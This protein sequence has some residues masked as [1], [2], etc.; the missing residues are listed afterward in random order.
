[1]SKVIKRWKGAIMRTHENIF[2]IVVI[3]MFSLLVPF[4]LFAFA[5]D[6]EDT[7][8]SLSGINGIHLYVQSLDPEIEKE[9]LTK[10]QIQTDIEL[11]LRMAEINIRSEEEKINDEDQ[12]IL[13]V[14]IFVKK[15]TEGSYDYSLSVELF[16]HAYLVRDI[17]DNE[18]LKLGLKVFARKYL[19]QTWSNGL[20]GMTNDLSKIRSSV[21]D[22]TDTFINAYL[23]VQLRRVR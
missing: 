18:S 1:M 13:F 12:G 10:K 16:Q 3:A 14:P 11:K 22:L 4:K 8:M 21:K 20:I 23:S 5:L 19:V 6:N 7:R 9:G 17:N 15:I 2:L